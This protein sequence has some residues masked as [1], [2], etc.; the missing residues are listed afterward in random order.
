MPLA[1]F[2][3]RVKVKG[4][5]WVSEQMGA[6]ELETIS[7][8]DISSHFAEKSSKEMRWKIVR[9]LGCESIVMRS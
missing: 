7:T 8:D 6:E 1:S 3:G 9:K 2:C 5:D 4:L